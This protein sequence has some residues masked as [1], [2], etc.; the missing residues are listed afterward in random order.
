MSSS[1]KPARKPLPSLP[2]QQLRDRQ[3]K[4]L[5]QKLKRARQRSQLSLNLLF[6]PQRKFA[7]SK[8]Q[9]LVACCSRR[10]GKSYGIAYK[11]LEKGIQYPQS[12][13]AYVT[14]T[15]DAGKDIIWGPLR[16]IAKAANITLRFKKNS[17]DIELPNGSKII[18]RGCE[19]K[20]QAEKLRG[21]KYPIVVI[22]EAQGIPSYLKYM[23]DEVI[24]PAT[25]DYVDSQICLTGTPNAA[26]VGVF[27]DA[28]HSNDEMQGWEVHEWTMQDN[29][30]LQKVQAAKNLT[31]L[32]YIE[33]QALKRG[34]ALTHPSIQR[35]FFGKWVK[36]TES[37]VYK[38][39]PSRND[40]Y[41]AAYYK[42]KARVTDWEFVMGLDL[43]WNDP[44]AFTVSMYSETVGKF[45]TVDSFQQ[46][47]M[48]TDAIARQI[49]K[50]FAVYGDMPIVADSGGYGKSIVEELAATYALPIFPAE[51]TKK[52][53][54]IEFVNADLR[55]GAIQILV[56]PNGELTE[57]LSL[58]Q[59][60]DRWAEKGTPK[61][62]KSSPN[63]LCDALLYSA[64]WALY[65]NGAREVVAPDVHTDAWWSARA[66]ELE[67][68]ELEQ[69]AREADPELELEDW[70]DSM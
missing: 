66:Q 62:D 27:F 54:Y 10:A 21:P 44:S 1:S 68:N 70:L 26:G 2:Q 14:L 43:G 31:I 48:S 56:G 65:Q 20:R 47:E 61:E 35:E 25:M 69:M 55:S 49:A 36:D 67:E 60:S 34:V 39:L 50:F 32:E 63:H 33:G 42:L 12:I 30:H 17:G 8:A 59:W 41:Q 6:A 40:I 29:T 51:K 15:R 5:E 13:C 19:D 64:R 11:L 16:E 45:I 9:N 28:V 4:L 57:Q 38:Y 3:R 23:I 7:A 22:D 53:T 46:S 24:T 52:V 58:L 37:N 18:L